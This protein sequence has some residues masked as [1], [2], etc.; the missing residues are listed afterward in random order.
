M[1]RR[2]SSVQLLKRI[3]LPAG[4]NQRR[5]ELPCIFNAELLQ[6]RLN[7]RLPVALSHWVEARGRGFAALDAAL[8][9]VDFGKLILREAA[10]CQFGRQCGP[11]RDRRS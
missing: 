5:R 8:E 10:V 9:P 2:K 4:G 7:G 3:L 11:G 6:P 1:S